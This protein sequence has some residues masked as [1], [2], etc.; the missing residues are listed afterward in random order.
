[1]KRTLNK[2]LV[3]EEAEP[4]E[5][6]GNTFVGFLVILVFILIIFGIIYYLEI[7]NITDWIK[8]F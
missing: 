4:K 2:K 7:N 6:K 8:F 5:Y 3:I 1:M